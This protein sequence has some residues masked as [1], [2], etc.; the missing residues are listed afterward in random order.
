VLTLFVIFSSSCKKEDEVLP[1]YVGTWIVVENIPIATGFISYREVMTFSQDSV[2]DLMQIPG[3][4]IDNWADYMNLKGSISVNGNIMT[5]N[6]NE[7]GM[8]S[9]DPIT[10]MPTG[11]LISYKETGPEFQSI[12]AAGEQPKVFESEYTVSGNKLTMKKDNNNDGDYLDSD[13]IT[14]YTKQ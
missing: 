8:S 7:I 4:S 13:E 1:D 11:T 10:G 12:L 14:V 6:I 5:I 9:L 2:I 3:R